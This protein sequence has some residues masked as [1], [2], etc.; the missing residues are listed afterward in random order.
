MDLHDEISKVA[1]ELY[2]SSGRLEGRD[3][4][5]WFEAESLVTQRRNAE[6][7]ADVQAGPG[8]EESGQ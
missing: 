7:K 2:E 8:P 6:E 5:N 1:F 4:E 3:L